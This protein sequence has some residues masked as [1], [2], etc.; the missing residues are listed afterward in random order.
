MVCAALAVAGRPTGPRWPDPGK[1]ASRVAL[2]L[3]VLWGILDE[4]H[5][6]QVPPRTPSA[7]DFLTDVTGALCV[8][9]V[10]RY[11]GRPDADER[12]V[13]LRLLGSLVFCTAAAGL[14]SLEK[15]L[16]SG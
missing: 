9:W 4:L 8:L 6:A 11:L 5:Q 7:F 12:G 14:A 3:V 16:L 2:L 1:R 13:R 15:V 10:A